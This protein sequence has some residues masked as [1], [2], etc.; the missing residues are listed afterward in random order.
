MCVFACA[1]FGGTCANGA[2]IAQS[3]RKQNHHCGQCNAGHILRSRQCQGIHTVLVL[4]VMSL[5]PRPNR[6][7]AYVITQR[8]ILYKYII[9]SRVTACNVPQAT[10]YSSGCKASACQAGY[11]V[12]NGKCAGA[13]T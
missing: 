2:L 8:D 1:G 13:I 9:H 4:Y 5:I 10:K 11:R 12:R 6:A 3:K 7:G